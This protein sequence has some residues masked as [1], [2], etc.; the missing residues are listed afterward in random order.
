MGRSL[1]CIS[2]R[3]LDRT[4]ETLAERFERHLET[5]R[6]DTDIGRLLASFALHLR[7]TNKSPMTVKS[8][9]D[10]VRQF[11]LFL[12]EHG[13]TTEVDRLTREHVEMFLVDQLNQF[14][15]K[16]AQIRFGDLQQF[17]KWAIEE[18]EIRISPMT[19]VKRPL[20]PE[21]P[22][23]VLTDEQLT[24]MLKTCAGDRFDDRRDAAINFGSSSIRV[25]A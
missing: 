25:C 18:R 10:T 21:A 11:C 2:T 22:P 9:S 7:G 19:N 17:F 3:S 24:A 23:P 15:P 1:K 16:T 12:A 6:Y 4:H 13:M 8:Y 14:R 5:A 20:V